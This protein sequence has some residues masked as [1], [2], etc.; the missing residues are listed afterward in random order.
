[1]DQF[2]YLVLSGGGINGLCQL[3]ALSA[4]EAILSQSIFNHFQ[5]FAGTSVGALVSLA[6]ACGKTVEDLF[7][8]FEDVRGYLSSI[9]VSLTHFLDTKGAT[10][11]F[12][13]FEQV[14]DSMLPF[15]GISFAELHRHTHK[16]LVVVTF[17]L[18]Q[19]KP[20]YFS[21]TYSPNV[22]VK[23]AVLASIAIP[24]ILPP[25]VIDSEILVDGGLGLNFPFSVFPEGKSLGVW[26]SEVLGQTPDVHKILSSSVTYLKLLGKALY[27]NHNI[28]FNEIVLKRR[29]NHIIVVP[30]L[31]FLPLPGNCS[32]SELARLQENGF[33]AALMHLFHFRMI[34]HRMAGVVFRHGIAS[35]IL[36]F[37]KPPLKSH[38]HDL[39]NPPPKTPAAAAPHSTLGN[40]SLDDLCR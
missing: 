27:L 10:G 18:S 33:M 1:M 5:G 16:T 17:S 13:P 32:H 15:A 14:I 34:T 28:V 19:L 37:P 3:G 7:Q 36:R 38:H 40:L 4:I 35:G 6:L 29:R 25:V 31:Y 9:R 21:H 12:F 8:Y 39:V 11:S 30:N 20:K 2:C 22:S 24:T 26:L 23:Q